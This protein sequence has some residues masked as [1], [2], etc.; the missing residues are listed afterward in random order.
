MAEMAATAELD[1]EE[2]GLLKRLELA[3][4]ELRDS[5]EETG[6]LEGD[7]N[8]GLPVEENISEE[9]GAN[10]NDDRMLLKGLESATL[11]GGLEDM[12]TVCE[13]I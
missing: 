4:D 1:M 8:A 6:L 3:T 11:E 7:E 10:A 5:L 13:D 2:D 9:L 12:M